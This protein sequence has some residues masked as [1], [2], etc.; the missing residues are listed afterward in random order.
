MKKLLILFSLFLIGFCSCN[1]DEEIEVIT[2]SSINGVVQKGPFLN[3]TSITVYELTDS[4]APTG[5]NYPSQIMDNSGVFELNNVSFISPYVLL[6]ANGYYFNEVTNENSISPVTLYA[7]TDIRDKS[8]VN[9]NILSNLEKSRMEYLI[10]EGKN[11]TEAKTV[12]TQEVLSIFSISKPDISDFEALD[13]SADGEDNAILLAVS[14]IVQGFRTESELSDLMANISTDIR[15]DGKLDSET[16]GS[17]LINDARLLNLAQIRT[18]IESRYAN[19]GRTVTIP[20]FEKYIQT[21]IDNTSYNITNQIE[22]PEFSDYGE[23]VLYGD[24][25]SFKTTTL[26]LAATL[27]VGTSLKVIIK[28]GMWWYRLAPEGP[29]NWTISSYD[30]TKEEQTY[31]VT[32][33]GKSCDVNIQFGEGD[34][35]LEIYENGSEVPT[36]TKVL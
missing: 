33:S 28:E 17:S 16:L 34:H 11:F 32:E 4:V 1:K 13:I 7:L 9:V 27:P 26:S 5:K 31:V 3:G 10:S 24:K 35:T 2:K 14:L 25:T 19:L 12:A 15:L 20:N 21:F 18:N 22:Y 6:M 23:N 36:R 30:N 8:T 29:V